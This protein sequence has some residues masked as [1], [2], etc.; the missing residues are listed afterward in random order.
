MSKTRERTQ[1]ICLNCNS[2]LYDRYCHKCGQENKEPKDTVWHLVTH[3]FYDITHFDGKFFGT[4]KYLVKKPGFLSSEYIKG[5]RNSYLNPIRMY[6]FTSA[7]FFLIFFSMFTVKEVSVPD[8]DI[9]F[10]GGFMDRM[11][12]KAYEGAETKQ[13]SLEIDS[14]INKFGRVVIPRPDTADKKV[15]DTLPD[16]LKTKSGLKVSGWATNEDM[17]LAQYDSIQ[18]SLPAEKRDNWLKR[19]I[20]RQVYNLQDRYKNNSQKFLADLLNKFL[21]TFPYL[22]FISL[23]LYAMFLKLLYVRRKQFWYVDHGIFLIHLYI[24]TFLLLLVIFLLQ[25]V[26][27][28]YDLEWISFIQLV[29]SLYGVYYAF[30]CMRNFYKQGWF[31]TFFK[32]ILLNSLAFVSI[33]FLFTFFFLLSIFQL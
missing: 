24:F 29:L 8:V 22:L 13:D 10:D 18:R 28:V 32:F 15:S 27:N 1:K 7:L 12:T 3:F 11:R 21:H 26:K 30:R 25:K 17:T 9:D 14:A 20:N 16:T 31:K 2:E 5:R 19:K 33:I 6:V 4:L 23:P